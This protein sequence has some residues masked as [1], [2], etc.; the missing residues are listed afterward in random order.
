MIPENREDAHLAGKLEG[1]PA[2]RPSVDH[3]TNGQDTVVFL[4]MKLL[5]DGLQFIEATMDIPDNQ[6]PA[7]ALWQLLNP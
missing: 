7:F 5:D 1:A 6:G 2:V 3:V 4:W